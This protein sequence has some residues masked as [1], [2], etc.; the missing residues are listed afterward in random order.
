[1]IVYINSKYFLVC[2]ILIYYY[3]GNL[4]KSRTRN[5]E[6]GIFNLTIIIEMIKFKIN[7]VQKYFKNFL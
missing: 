1:M 2:L 7:F 6:F 3:I 5:I 4:S